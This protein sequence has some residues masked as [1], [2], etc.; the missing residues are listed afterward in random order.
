MA[1]PPPF[2]LSPKPVRNALF[3]ALAMTLPYL[4]VAYFTALGGEGRYAGIAGEHGD[5][6]VDVVKVV[7]AIAVQ[8]AKC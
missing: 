7:I 5:E 2:I 6:I 8:I 4:A 3:A 1:P